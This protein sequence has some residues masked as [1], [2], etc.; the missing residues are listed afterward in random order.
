MSRNP[1]CALIAALSLPLVA[2]MDNGISACHDKLELGILSPAPNALFAQGFSIPVQANVRSSCGTDLANEGF[3][4]LTST[5][6]GELGGDWRIEEGKVIFDTDATLRLGDHVLTLRG[7][8]NDGSSGEDTVT[9]T[10][11]ENE[12]PTIDLTTPDELGA[13][14][15]TTET[16][17]I[18]G[19][20]EDNAEPL[21]SLKLTWTINGE[22]YAGPES[23]DKNGDFDFIAEVDG[24]CHSIEVTVT[25]AVD[26]SASDQGDFVLWTESSDMNAFLWWL[27]E[28]EDGWG[29]PQGEILA[30]EAPEGSVAF[31]VEED[32][33]DSNSDV[34]PG[35]AD[36]CGDGI[37][38]DCDP[39]TPT[40]CFP[41][42]EVDAEYA[43]ASL[44]G[45]SVKLSR[46]GDLNND[47]N[48]DFAVAMADL[49]TQIV[50]GPVLGDISPG[51]TLVSLSTTSHYYLAG[52]LGHGMAGGKDVDGDGVADLLLGNPDWTWAC[53]SNSN[54]HSG[55]AYL[56]RG[57]SVE[58]GI[59]EDWLANA[60]DWESGDALSLN[61]DFESY[62]SCM[63]M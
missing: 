5:E 47:G 46:A 59:M 33:N 31:T 37:D 10:I 50:F 61:T 3:F 49:S 2:C 21:E 60:S 14:F 25:D 55:R 15:S 24:G 9:I 28:D 7:V 20:V 43:N 22:P 58:S 62:V 53:S 11:V 4:V 30:C 27:D 16:V 18:Q 52:Q 19:W 41:W 56:L 34:Y 39:I 8:S 12:P 29:V 44:S 1:H 23:P 57:G 54:S 48:D 63:G 13:N 38:S 6:E 40:G 26:Q 35:H 36:Y 45:S 17:R 51:A 42:G 32:C